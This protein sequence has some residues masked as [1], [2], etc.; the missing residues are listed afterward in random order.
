MSRLGDSTLLG[1]ATGQ[2]G[3]VLHPHI[4]EASNYG[5]IPSIAVII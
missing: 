4:K 3:W 5:Y 2:S 1:M